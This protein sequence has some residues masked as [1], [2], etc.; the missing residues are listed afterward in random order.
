MPAVVG[1]SARSPRSASLRVSVVI[2][3]TP[4]TLPCGVGHGFERGFSLPSDVLTF[5][6]PSQ[7]RDI[8]RSACSARTLACTR[9]TPKPLHEAYALRCSW[10]R[11][12]AATSV[13]TAASDADQLP[14]AQDGTV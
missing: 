8:K 10:G 14:G 11:I 1:M 7:S 2:R 4:P 9:R 5:E 13:H 3:T 6:A 12:S